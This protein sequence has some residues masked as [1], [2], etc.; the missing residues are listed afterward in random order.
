[1]ASGHRA[2]WKGFLK[3]GEVSC[4]VAL[5]TAA[6]TSERITFNT[7]NKATGNRVNRIFVDSE[8][9]DP[10]PK[11]EQTKGFEVDD[12]RYI[13]IDPEEIAAAIP[14]ATRRSRS[15]LSSPAPR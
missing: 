5:Y 13:M 12:G 1:M 11:E 8:T 2:Q 10:V 7:I 14:K 3:V 4:G 6:S 15:R 9:D